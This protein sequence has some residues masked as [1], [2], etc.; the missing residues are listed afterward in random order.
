MF[1]IEV[2]TRRVHIAGCTPHPQHGWVEQQARQM[3]WQIEGKASSIHFLIHDRDSSFTKRFDEVF[4]SAGIHLII[5]TQTPR[6]KVVDGVIKANFPTRIAFK[7]VSRLESE[8]ILDRAG[9]EVLLGKGDMLLV[10]T[11]AGA[12]RLQGYNVDN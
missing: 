9:A 12:E 3:V 7:T 5:T 4:A 11:S 10:G 1:F 2:G 8:I 6:A